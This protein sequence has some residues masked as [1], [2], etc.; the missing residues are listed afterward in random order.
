M[1]DITEVPPPGKRKSPTRE[2]LETLALAL[3][4]ALVIRW[5]LVEVYRVEG[6]SMEATLHSGERVLVNKFTYRYVRGPK[7]GDIVVFQYPKEPDRDF[8]KRVVAVAGDSVEIREGKV[9]V[10]GQLFSEAPSVRLS[11]EDSPA[12]VTVP[13]DSVWVLGD[14]RNNSEDSRWFGPVSLAYIRGMAFFRVWPLS[15]MCRFVNSVDAQP[16]SYQ[17]VFVCP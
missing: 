4:I 6:T 3:I 17:G 15:H 5:Q 11:E 1:A 7:P 8:I 10:N 9:Y 16:S 2:V 12:E 13:P 14:N